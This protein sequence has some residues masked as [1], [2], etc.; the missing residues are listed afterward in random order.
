[1]F[2][3]KMNGSLSLFDRIRKIGTHDD[4]D[5]LT[6]NRKNFVV[7]E[8]FL[9]SVG[10]ILWGVLCLLLD[11]KQQAIIP[12]SYTFLSF[13]NVW[14]FSRYKNFKFTQGFQTAI[15]LLLPFLFQ[16]HLGGFAASGVVMIWALLAFSAS[17]SYTE[18]R[19]SYI[20]LIIYV[21]LAVFSAFIDESVRELFPYEISNRTAVIFT[22]MN[23]SF[24]SVFVSLLTVFYI[25]QNTRS[26]K[27]AEEVKDLLIDS[28]K[29]VA[30]GQLSAGIMH[31]INTPLGSIKA[32]SKNSI[33]LWSRI[34]QKLSSI[35]KMSNEQINELYDYIESLNLYPAFSSA[36]DRR[37]RKLEL[38]KDLIKLGF[39][40]AK[41]ISQKLVTIGVFEIPPFLNKVD[42]LHREDIID[43]LY[44]EFNIYRNNIIMNESVERASRITAALR[45]YTHFDTNEEM[46]YHNLRKSLD[47]VLT[48]YQNELKKGIEIKMDVPENIEVYSKFDELNQ[49]WANLL[50]NAIHALKY[51][52]KI[53]I[54][55][56]YVDKY[57]V[58][59]ISDNGTG[60]PAEYHDRIFDAFFTTKSSG[61]GSGLGL[62]I[63][64]R[65]LTRNEGAISFKS[66]MG[67]GTTFYVKLKAKIA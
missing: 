37:K 67:K 54:S 28:E 56:K 35:K 46:K 40:N 59:S 43:L 64:K 38:E 50:T 4:D 14:F 66:E 36:V 53:E 49:V 42:P 22:A 13:M 33:D 12:L 47:T 11:R 32:L 26:F 39:D 19:T 9:M 31:E 23:I 29:L 27:K 60:I 45:V 6:V 63:V 55:S 30:L 24:V 52:G 44:I 17:L 2:M 16:W 61:D 7:Y 48:L 57:V 51:S 3:F 21:L 58:V 62:D 41:L 34:R 5:S 20:W 65:T 18:T 25:N 8:A 10:G 15:S 1:M